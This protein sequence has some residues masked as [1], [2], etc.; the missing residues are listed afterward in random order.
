MNF[1]GIAAIDIG[2]CTVDALGF[3]AN[4]VD[5]IMDCDIVCVVGCIFCAVLGIVCT[6]GVVDNDTLGSFVLAC[7]LE[8]FLDFV[9]TDVDD[10][11]GCKIV[12]TIEKL[13][14]AMGC[15]IGILDGFAVV[16]DDVMGCDIVFAVGFCWIFCV[17]HVGRVG[18]LDGCVNV[19]Y[20]ALGCLAIACVFESFRSCLLVL[21]HLFAVIP[22]CLQVDNEEILLMLAPNILV[23][24]QNPKELKNLIISAV[25]VEA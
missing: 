6:I 17:V 9:A 4:A 18:I 15:T 8:S 14:C 20:I 13:D 22:L 23:H 5:A 2:N 21:V 24:N 11:T 7:V 3:V 19:V 10:I 16:V 25:C 12:C 1:C